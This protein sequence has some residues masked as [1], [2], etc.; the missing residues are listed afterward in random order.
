MTWHIVYLSYES[1]PGGRN[2]IGKHSTE[3]IHDGYLGSF[4]DS[5]F[6]PDSKIILGVFK[7]SEAAILAEIQWQRAFKVVSNPD[8]VN[9]S[10][11]TS[12]K[13]DTTGAIPHNK[14]KPRT[15]EEKKKISECTKRALKEKGFDNSGEKNP[16]YGLR[17]EKHHGFGKKR[18]AET[19][20]RMSKA[21]LGKP[22]TEEHRAALSKAK[23]GNQIRRGKKDSEETRLKKSKALLGR[24]RGPHTEE[25]KK[26][27]SETR[28]KNFQNF[29]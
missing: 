13:F 10:Y 18:S 12:K 15:E 20:E 5:S 14:G 6:C 28:K 22:L 24:K 2:Y 17:G 27:M 29:L 23:L 1:K 4:S 19:V 3:C 11:Q 8:F 26:K 25:S 7:T 16:M 9:K 21:R